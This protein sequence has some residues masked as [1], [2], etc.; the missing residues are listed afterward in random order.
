MSTNVIRN[1]F[2]GW[3]ILSALVLVSQIGKRRYPL[4]SG[5]AVWCFVF[6]GVSLWGI[7]VLAGR[8]V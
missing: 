3:Y 1:L 5:G 4:T 6:S 8:A 7:L 2:I